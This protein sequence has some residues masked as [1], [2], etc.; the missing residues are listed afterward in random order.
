MLPTSKRSEM[1]GQLVEAA[2]ANSPLYFKYAW[3]DCSGVWYVGLGVG[4]GGA[5]H[6]G[7]ENMPRQLAHAACVAAEVQSLGASVGSR[8]G[9]S[10]AASLGASVGSRVGASVAASLGASV[11]S[12]VGAS[13]GVGVGDGVGVGA[14]VGVG[15]GSSVTM[16]VCVLVCTL[17]AISVIWVHVPWGQQVVHCP[18]V[19]TVRQVRPLQSM[20]STRAAI[21]ESSS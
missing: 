16:H 6:R 15:V 12:G 5:T 19:V 13:V 2:W 14:S 18:C 9:A 8:V 21:C 4:L 1:V 11:G 10:V 7:A 3:Y 17:F 20:V